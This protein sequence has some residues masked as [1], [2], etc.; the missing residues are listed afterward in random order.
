MPHIPTVRTDNPPIVIALPPKRIRRQ[1]QAAALSRVVMDTRNAPPPMTGDEHDARHDADIANWAVM[2]LDPLYHDSLV[3][4][5]LV[6]GELL[7]RFVIVP[8][9]SRPPVYI[10]AMTG[11]NGTCQKGAWVNQ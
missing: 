2:R 1:L 4:A 10:C 9:A 8:A 3:V 11:S 6:V 5:A 7:D